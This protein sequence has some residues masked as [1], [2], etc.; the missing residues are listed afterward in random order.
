VF[1]LAWLLLTITRPPIVPVR[2]E[3]S[4]HV[5]FFVSKAALFAL[6]WLV[7]FVADQ[8]RVCL[9]FFRYFVESRAQYTAGHGEW[10]PKILKRF[11]QSA[12]ATGDERHLLSDYVDIR[13][14]AE[15]SKVIGDTVY[16]PFLALVLFVA[17]RVEF[18][19]AWTWPLALGLL[20][21]ACFVLLVLAFT[22]L[23]RAAARA[24]SRAI[25]RLSRKYLE[26]IGAGEDKRQLAAQV[27]DTL[28]HV[29][30]IAE[31]AFRPLSEE[32]LVRA[33]II[34]TG[35]LSGLGA[36]QYLFVQRF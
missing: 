7:F 29:Q 25:S 35:G 34:P 8:V 14:L 17:A 12:A 30:S 18:F 6:M 3:I 24:R 13:L 20:A 28:E 15:R 36:L 26:L 10:S 19:D 5:E 27:K 22:M 9:G 2:G 23:R 11:G 33:L 4:Y 1:L 32:P 16:Y 31:G 21:G